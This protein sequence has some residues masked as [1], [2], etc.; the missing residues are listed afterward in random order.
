VG[1]RAIEYRPW[2]GDRTDPNRRWLV[3]SWHVFRKNVRAKAVIVLLIFGM[4]LAHAFPIIGAV[5]FPHEGITDED[6]VGSDDLFRED[7]DPGNGTE[8]EF[9]ND[10]TLFVAPTLRFNGTFFVTGIVA[11]YGD[12][13]LYGNVSGSGRVDAFGP[14]EHDGNLTIDGN[15]FLEGTL[16]LGQAGDLPPEIFD[17]IPP[18]AD[19]E[20]LALLEALMSGN[21]TVDIHSSINGSGSVSGFGVMFGFGKVT[22]DT[23]PEEPIIIDFGG[24]EG[25]LTNGIFIIFTMLLAAIICAD[26]IAADLADSSFVLYFSRPVRSFDYLLGKFVGLLWVMWLFCLIPPIVYVLVM[27]GTMSGDDWGGAA[28][29]L[30][31]TVVAGLITAIYFLPYGLM[32]SSFTKS[33]AYAGIGIFM[34]FFVLSIVA[35]I[36]SNESDLWTLIDPFQLLFNMYKIMFNGTIP[37]GITSGQVGGSILAFTVIPMTIVI[38]WIYRKGAGK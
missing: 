16:N 3:I 26:I 8:P 28:K 7:P 1:I 29:I 32:I 9:V 5:L 35:E 20:I 15:V 17:L 4:M 22:G 6:M 12:L 34:S 33:K 11:V 30:G 10:T 18:D 21:F 25:Y 2:K 23:G 27:M 14:S 24:L 13:T 38:Y 31:K 37:E 36:F 19:P